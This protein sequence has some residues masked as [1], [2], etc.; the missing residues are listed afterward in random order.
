MN[1]NTEENLFPDQ[2]I[3]WQSE[4]NAIINDVGKHVKEIIVSN[5]LPSSRLEIFFNLTTLEDKKMCIR[6]SSEGFQVVGNEYDNI[7]TLDSDLGTEELNTRIYET[8]YALLNDVS[9][10]YIK[11]FGDELSSA[12]QKF[13]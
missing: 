4:A 9:E 2:L 6:I 7:Q 8:P 11:S 13:I 5:K 3:D 12:L 1:A 10:K